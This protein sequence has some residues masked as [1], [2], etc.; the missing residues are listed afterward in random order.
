MCNHVRMKTIKSFT[1]KKSYSTS[2]TTLECFTKAWKIWRNDTKFTGAFVANLHLSG[3]G[4]NYSGC[5]FSKFVSLT[6]NY[7]D[8]IRNFVLFNLV[9]MLLKYYTQHLLLF[10]KYIDLETRVR[11]SHRQWNKKQVSRVVLNT[12]FHQEASV[13]TT[14]I[15]INDMTFFH[16]TL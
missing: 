11:L 16:P 14:K 9:L 2:F 15:G 10:H 12:M 13:E 3:M 1:F 6:W 7:F 4:S 5:D 8:F